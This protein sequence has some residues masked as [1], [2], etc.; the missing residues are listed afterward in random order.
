MNN[1]LIFY[2]DNNEANP[3]AQ[4]LYSG[5]FGVI[6][7][8][9]SGE[10]IDFSDNTVYL[11]N[12]DINSL[13]VSNIS[14][15]SRIVDTEKE[16]RYYEA[17]YAMPSNEFYSKWKS[18]PNFDKTDFNKWADLYRSLQYAKK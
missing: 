6:S 8:N 2:S 4:I 14:D 5:S 11:K 3:N 1:N 13:I 10:N 7:E 12:D 18:D 9:I 17:R 16:I 15:I